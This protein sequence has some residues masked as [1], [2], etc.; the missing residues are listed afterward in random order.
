MCL[1]SLEEPT[2]TFECVRDI[3]DDPSVAVRV[4]ATEESV[5]EYAAK[6]AD[7]QV[8]AQPRHS[9]GNR[10]A[11]EVRRA[12]SGLARVRRLLS[13]DVRPEERT[14]SRSTSSSPFDGSFVCSQKELSG[15]VGVSSISRARVTARCSREFD[16]VRRGNVRREEVVRDSSSVSKGSDGRRVS[17][18]LSRRQM[19]DCLPLRRPGNDFSELKCQTPPS[20][21]I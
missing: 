19:N 11:N 15:R 2:K 6:D 12:E 20:I 3:F 17:K 1:R 21:F 9:R 18:P 16:A 13:A 10:H 5:T 4:R 7:G 8:G 14:Q